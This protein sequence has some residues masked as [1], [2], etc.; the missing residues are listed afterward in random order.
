MSESSQRL[1][2]ANECAVR[3]I[4]FTLYVEKVEA[5]V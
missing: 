3:N 5:R 1:W 4:E 2:M